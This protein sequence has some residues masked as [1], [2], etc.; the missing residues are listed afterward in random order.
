MNAFELDSFTDPGLIRDTASSYAELRQ[1][2]LVVR[3]P[4]W[5]A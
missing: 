3:E 4:H 5:G 2:G 1:R